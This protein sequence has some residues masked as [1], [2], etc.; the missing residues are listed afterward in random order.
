MDCVQ[1]TSCR[2]ITGEWPGFIPAE[3]PIPVI[4]GPVFWAPCGSWRPVLLVGSLSRING[5]KQKMGTCTVLSIPWLALLIR[6]HSSFTQTTHQILV[7]QF[8]N[9]PSGTILPFSTVS[10]S[11]IGSFISTSLSPRLF[12]FALF[13]LSLLQHGSISAHVQAN[14]SIVQSMQD[15]GIQ[16]RTHPCTAGAGRLPPCSLPGAVSAQGALAASSPTTTQH[17]KGRLE[18]IRVSRL[19]NSWLST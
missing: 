18:K 12:S 7:S 17:C 15:S 8:K 13:F 6:R 4:S 11:L 1:P 14:N 16:I 2:E 5:Q 10:G 9:R 3:A 19:G